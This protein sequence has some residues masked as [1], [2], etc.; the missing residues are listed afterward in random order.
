MR[1]K[2]TAHPSPG[3]LPMTCWVA[4]S[5]LFLTHIARGTPVWEIN[6]VGDMYD[7]GRDV[8]HPT[9]EKPAYYFPIIG[10][11]QEM[12]AKVKGVQPPPTKDIVHALATALA[13]EG[14]L[15]SHEVTVPA[16]NGGSTTAKALAPP[17]SL[18]LVFHWGYLNPEKFDDGSDSS[19]PPAIINGDQMLGLTAGRKLDSIFDSDFQRQAIMAGIQ[20]DR[21]FV[22]ISAYDFNAYNQQHKKVR[23]WVAKMSTPSGGTTLADALPVLIKN[24]GAIFGRETVGPKSIDVPV[25]PEGRVEVG[26]PTVVPEVKK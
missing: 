3:C 12:G 19:S 13:R 5:A 4:V 2:S 8:P 6:L 24:G 17:P 25:V 10:G 14:Y 21:F 15:V 22:M 20:D 18:V 16:P 1:S 26:T 11:F 9:P 7:D 23:L